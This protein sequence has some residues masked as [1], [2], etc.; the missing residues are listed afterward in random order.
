MIYEISSAVSLLTSPSVRRHER[1]P[2]CLPVRLCSKHFMIR[3]PA[4][5][6]NVSLGGV[7]LYTEN[8]SL[9]RDDKVCVEFEISPTKKL[10]MV[11]TVKWSNLFPVHQS[12]TAGKGIG[13]HFLDVDNPEF[14]QWILSL[15]VD[16]H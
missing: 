2:V 4:F 15:G 8:Y 12:P 10:S 1:L 13:I 14:K 7:F 5:T 9:D 6:A 11:G 3:E 16:L